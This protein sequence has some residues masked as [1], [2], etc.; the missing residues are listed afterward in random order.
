MATATKKRNTAADSDQVA[1]L[2]DFEAIGQEQEQAKRDAIALLGEQL[3]ALAA[4]EAV[5]R[6]GMQ[7]ALELVGMT[8][9]QLRQHAADYR[10]MQ[11]LQL[12]Y[13]KYDRNAMGAELRHWQTEY[14]EFLRMHK[15]RRI[16]R[17]G[18]L[19]MISSTWMGVVKLRSGL[20][21]A[22]LIAKPETSSEDHVVSGLETSDPREP[23][24]Q[25]DRH[26]DRAR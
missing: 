23:R 2:D 19:G 20:E 11:R 17:R 8:I 26:Y 7:A 6:A 18:L 4:G 24:G 16:K 5:N 15:E 13:D 12:E 25:L 14:D 10:E 21:A 22:G 3:P 9:E 1:T